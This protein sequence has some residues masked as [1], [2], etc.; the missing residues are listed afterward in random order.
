[1]FD[2]KKKNYTIKNMQ[3]SLPSACSFMGLLNSISHE[4][5]A[6]FSN[7]NFPEQSA[8]NSLK[9]KTGGS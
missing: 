1:M 2:V 3:L 8:R 4:E 9:H 7:I 5:E 6:R